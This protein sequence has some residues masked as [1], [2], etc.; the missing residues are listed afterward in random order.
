MNKTVLIVEDSLETL[1]LLRRIIEKQGYT[2]ILAS[3]GEKGLSYAQRFS[4][5]IIILDRLLPKMDGL[6][7]C[8]I[9]K[10]ESA[11]ED[12]PIIFLSVLGSEKDIVEGLKSG[13]DDYIRKPFSPDELIARVETVLR[14]YQKKR[15]P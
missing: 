11:A 8:R 3:D 15:A 13:A 9:L 14:R 7:V 6:Q 10:A 4:P 2:A 1:E 12:I 5:A